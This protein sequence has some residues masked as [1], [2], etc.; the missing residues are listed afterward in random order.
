MTPTRVET[1]I[2]V[3]FSEECEVNAIGL[4]YRLEDG[5]ERLF[6][7]DSRGFP[8]KMGDAFEVKELRVDDERR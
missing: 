6:A 1:G 4:L 2:L 3:C 7:D 8:L 5:G